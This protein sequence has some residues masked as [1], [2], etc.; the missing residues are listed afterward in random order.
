MH[1]LKFEIQL[2]LA[3]DDNLTAWP[4]VVTVIKCQVS[5]LMIGW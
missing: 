5:L 4:S 3:E 1:V 2:P